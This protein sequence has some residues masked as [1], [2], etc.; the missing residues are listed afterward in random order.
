MKVL[1]KI[2]VILLLLPIISCSKKSVV[3]SKINRNELVEIKMPRS[4]KLDSNPNEIIKEITFLP[5]ENSDLCQ[6]VDPNKVVFNENRY[7]VLDFLKALYVFDNEG[8]YLHQIGNKGKGPGEF[9]E[10]RD[11]DISRDGKIVILDFNRILKYD[12]DGSFEK[13]VT[14]YN[15]FKDNQYCN[16]FQ[17]ASISD[18][19]FY[20]WGGSMG[21]K[22]YISNNYAMYRS[23]E[24]ILSEYYFPVTHKY[25]DDSHRFI[26]H[27][28][29]YLI[30]PTLGN[31]TIYSIAK[32]RINTKY[33]IIF[34]NRFTLKNEINEG[35]F[36]KGYY[37][38]AYYS[39]NLSHSISNPL[40]TS[41][42]LSFSFN[43]NQKII[44][45]F[46]NKNNHSIYTFYYKYDNSPFPMEL[47]FNIDQSFA[48]ILSALEAKT[49]LDKLKRTKLSKFEISNH[50]SF[51]YNDNHVIVIYKLK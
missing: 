25:N 49:L 33:A 12:K 23:K 17:F 7:Y 8:N 31:D 44:N 15:F 38:E 3:Q 41:N 51:E 13:I 16:P 21:Q 37:P 6:I 27:N 43:F 19:D 14:N 24:T 30:N 9:I 39:N 50:K 46:I 26:K 36:L 2:F 10:I 48:C 5:L 35:A 1:L 47:D 4:Y 29:F 18:N 28:N 32:N 42:W 20:I 40:E 11:F 22:K 45:T 34:K